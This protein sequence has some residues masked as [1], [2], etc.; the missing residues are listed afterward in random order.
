MFK[1]AGWINLQK[2]VD[3]GESAE[4]RKRRG[5][6]HQAE[7]ELMQQRERVGEM[8][9]ALP[10][11]AAVKEDYVFQEGPTGLAAG[12]KPVRQVRLSE[13]F[14]APNRSLVVYHFMYG[15]GQ[16]RACPM[17]TMWIDG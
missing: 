4:Y 16:K 3:C 13:L 9:R 1:S 12:H 8:R 6:P 7:R 14:T 10:T 15:K 17:C 2:T 11:G 5:E